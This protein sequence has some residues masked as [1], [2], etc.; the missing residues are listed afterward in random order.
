MRPRAVAPP[1]GDIAVGTMLISNRSFVKASGPTVSLTLNKAP[2]KDALMSLAR[3]GGYGIVFVS[4]SD[5][6]SDVDNSKHTVTMAFLNERYDRAL[7]SVL[8]SSGLQGRLDGNT[9]LVGTS[10][11]AKSFGPQMSKVFRMNQVDVESASQYLG[12]LGAVMNSPAEGDSDSSVT[13]YSSGYGPLIGLTGTFDTRLNTITLVGGPKLVSIAE[14]YLKQIDLRKRQVAVKVQIL[15]VD[16]TNAKSIDSSFPQG[17]E[18][19]SC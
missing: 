2:A 17:L 5:A 6:S 19:H 15:N 14:S 10:V 1:L 11:S 18:I 13:S 7:N 16:L 3:L 9:L 4:N 8:M 12:N